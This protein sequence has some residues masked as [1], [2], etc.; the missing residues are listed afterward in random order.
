MYN[1]P[2]I[3][4][5]KLMDM[6]AEPTLVTSDNSNRSMVHA[7]IVNY[8]PG[9]LKVIDLVLLIHAHNYKDSK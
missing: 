9:Q 6:Y 5:P 8:M 4:E 1:A 2:I 3:N 7:K